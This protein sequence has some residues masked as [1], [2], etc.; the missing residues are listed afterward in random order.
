MEHTT[1]IIIPTLNSQCEIGNL[2][3]SLHLQ[4]VVP[5]EILVIDSSSDDETVSIC[6]QFDGVNVRVIEREE[7][8]H[9]G[10][11]HLGAELT[12]GDFILFLTQDA[13][14]ANGHYI[15][16]LIAPLVADEKIAMVT[17]RQVPKE[18]ARRHVQLVQE[19]NY[20]KTSNVREASDIEKMGIKAF[21][22]SDVCSAYRRSA[23]LECGGFKRPLSTNED[24]LMAATFLKNGWKVAYEASAEVFHSHNLSLKEQFNRNKLVG[25]FLK[26]H[27]DELRGIKETSEG[28]KLARD[29]A[30]QLAKEKRPSELV[31]FGLDCAARLLG[32][33]VGRN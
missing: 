33:R 16:S 10:T 7:F 29:V 20:P 6:K 13:I 31:K 9:G 32:N 22:A 11:R 26:E 17:G 18:G 4:T 14:P 24:M 3:K 1:S 2:L 27:A 12:H 25:T 23:Y 30:H 8:N 19:F 5:D 15:E 28:K 21:F